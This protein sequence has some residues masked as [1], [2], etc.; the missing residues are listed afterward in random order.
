MAPSVSHGFVSLGG[1]KATEAG[2][3]S[4]TSV[5]DAARLDSVS[6]PPMRLRSLAHA[7][8]APMA[9]ASGVQDVRVDTA[10]VVAYQHTQAPRTVFE[11]DFD[12]RWR[13]HAGRR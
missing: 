10:P 11:L 1:V 6:W 12:F 7:G 8:Q 9:I 13:A 4:S 5:P 2:S 3:R